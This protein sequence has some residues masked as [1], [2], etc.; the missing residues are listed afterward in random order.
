M[1]LMPKP[2]QQE[3]RKSIQLENQKGRAKFNNSIGFD[4]APNLAQLGSRIPIPFGMYQPD[5]T[6]PTPDLGEFFESG[7]IVVEPLLVWSR[8]TSYG[9]YQA[10]KFL[11]VLGTSRSLL[12]PS[13]QPSCLAV[14]AWRTS[15]RPTT[16]SAGRARMT[17]TS[18][19]CP[20]R[21][22]AKLQEGNNSGDGIFICPTFDSPAERGFSQVYTPANT[23]SFGVYEPLHNGGNWRLN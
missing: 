6:D 17:R 2:K 15:T 14:R 8:M 1:L 4:G 7:G 9:K 3:E 16:G 19:S 10:L 12:R 13:C 23:N 18:F 5:S 11:T 20:T 22:M 21:F